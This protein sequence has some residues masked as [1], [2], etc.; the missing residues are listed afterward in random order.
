MD[1]LNNEKYLRLL[2]II[3][4]PFFIFSLVTTVW[5]SFADPHD[6]ESLFG[7]TQYLFSGH[8]I[9]NPVVIKQFGL[10]SD[11]WPTCYAM[12]LP[13]TFFPFSQANVFWLIINLALTILLARDLAE[14]YLGKN[15]FWLVLALMV[16]SM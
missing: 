6:F 3:L 7:D 5:S 15:Y 10:G 13:L 9:Y 16:C 12:L 1:I 11:Y 2:K 8:D 4:L 14:L